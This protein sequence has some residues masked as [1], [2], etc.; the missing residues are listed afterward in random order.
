MII[1]LHSSKAMRL[2]TDAGHRLTVPALLDRAR[3]LAAQVRA[4]EVGPLAEMMSVTAGVAEKTA[5]QMAEWSADEVYLALPRPGGD[6][7]LRID[8]RSGELEWEDSERGWI[9]ISAPLR[10]A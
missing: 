6:A 3:V 7:W 1:L 2:A 5:A 10:H 4:M 8:R 9:A